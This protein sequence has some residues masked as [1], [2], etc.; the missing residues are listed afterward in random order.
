[1]PLG[2]SARAD[3]T[4]PT[5]EEKEALKR[6]KYYRALGLRLLQA[7]V[8]PSADRRLRPDRLAGRPAGVD[9]R[10]VL[11]LDGLRRPPGER[12][13]QGRTARQR[14][15]VLGHRIGRVVGANVL[16]EFHRSSGASAASNC[17]RGSLVPEGDPAAAAQLV[18]N[19]T[20][21]SPIGRR[22]RAAGISPRS[23]SP[24][25]SSRTSGSSSRRCADSAGFDIALGRTGAT[26]GAE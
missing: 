4:D 7:A 12:A 25:C 26:P 23:S 3:L 16:G 9:R 15:D 21:T 5:P 13:E 17:P 8:H 20:T 1:M 14:D 24:S 6:L 18:P 2:V 19:R 22:C 11:G 10:E